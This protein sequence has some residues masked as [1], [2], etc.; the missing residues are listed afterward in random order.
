MIWDRRISS[1]RRPS[2]ILQPEARTL[3]II[4]SFVGPPM[5]VGMYKCDCDNTLLEYVMV[6]IYRLYVEDRMESY[7]GSTAGEL[8]TRLKDHRAKGNHATAR[9]LFTLGVVKMEVLEICEEETRYVRERYWIENT[10]GVVNKA[11]PGR[12]GR[13]KAEYDKE[14][15]MNNR[16][17]KNENQ[18]QYYA[19]KKL[20][21]EQE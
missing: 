8:S 18:R 12:P 15:Q 20:E 10:P 13:T 14:W 21:Q 1:S 6:Y 9:I 17:R 2:S 16:E 3:K 19:R 11:L 5:T 4:S 7:V